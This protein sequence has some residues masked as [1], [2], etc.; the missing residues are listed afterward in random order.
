MSHDPDNPAEGHD[1]ALSRGSSLMYEWAPQAVIDAD[2][3]W[4][5][6]SGLHADKAAKQN[7][8]ILVATEKKNEAARQASVEGNVSVTQPTVR[9]AHVVEA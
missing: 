9:G 2:V 6:Y 4:S 8:R 7:A 5:N 3:Y 1:D